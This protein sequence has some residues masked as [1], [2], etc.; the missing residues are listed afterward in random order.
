MYEHIVQAVQALPW[1]ILPEKLA[2]IREI[3][4]LRATGQRFTL[5]EIRAALQDEKLEAAR[6]ERTMGSGGNAV[7]VIPIVGTL[8][9]RGNMLLESR[10]GVR[11]QRVAA[12][13]RAALSD[14]GGGSI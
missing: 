6:S 7:A 10:G 3:L 11:G 12:R 2:V 13:V 5:E 9:P 14:P 4:I 1:A 8:M